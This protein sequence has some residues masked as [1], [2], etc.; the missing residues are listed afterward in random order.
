MY[1]G[2][3]PPGMTGK[4]TG[5]EEGG[6]EWSGQIETCDEEVKQNAR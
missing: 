1:V 5:R 2:G 4:M 6:V 3:L